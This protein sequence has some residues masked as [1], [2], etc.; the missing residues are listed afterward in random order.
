MTP[1]TFRTMMAHWPTGV[2]VLTISTDSGIGGATVNSL[3][4]A[5]LRPPLLAVFLMPHGMTGSLAQPGCRVALNVL[6]AG[7]TDLA[8]AF[9]APCP[10]EGYPASWFNGEGQL[11]LKGALMTIIGRVTD[12]YT[13]G[14]HCLALVAPERVEYDDTLKQ[15]LLFYRRRY[16][17]WTAEECHDF[18]A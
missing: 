9:A 8:S 3:T 17:T 18:S 1:E 12:R 16:G 10:P 4:S 6:S 13:I 7:A 14:D 11:V 15:P 2:A 5:S